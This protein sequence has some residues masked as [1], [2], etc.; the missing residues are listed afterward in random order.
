M[1][2]SDI[3]TTKPISTTKFLYDLEDHIPLV[4]FYDLK[5][6]ANERIEIR[7]H[8]YQGDGYR[9]RT[10]FSAWLDSKPVML[11]MTAGR[12]YGRDEQR[13]YIVD[14]PLYVDMLSYIITLRQWEDI[15][16]IPLDEEYEELSALYGQPLSIEDFD[17]GKN[18][19]TTTD[20][21][22]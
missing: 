5:E 2:P 9:G 7:Q 21:N 16:V 11:C 10:V 8:L 3:L 20:S 13:T 18:D 14:K 4:G 15:H 22:Q 12:G 6:E 17:T 19:T 1:K